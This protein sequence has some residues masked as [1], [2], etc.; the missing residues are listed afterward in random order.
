[1]HK[2]IHV[3]NVTFGVRTFIN[4][5]IRL[6]Q[7]TNSQVLK[8]LIFRN[9]AAFNEWELIL[10]VNRST[11]TDNQPFNTIKNIICS[12]NCFA[13]S[14]IYIYHTEIYMTKI[15][16]TIL[17]FTARDRKNTKRTVSTFHLIIGQQ[18]NAYTIIRKQTR[19]FAANRR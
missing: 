5:V 8:H 9:L 14:R 12:L 18:T 13:H 2:S 4:S 11:A 6:K 7:G 19:I 17:K 10:L 3:S 15:I 16:E 1:M